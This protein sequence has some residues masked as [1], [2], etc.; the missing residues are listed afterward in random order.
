MFN[1]GDIVKH[2]KI[3]PRVCRELIGIIVEIDKATPNFPY[4]VMWFN[5][6]IS[7][8]IRGYTIHQLIKVS[9]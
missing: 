2:Y 6:D 3:E 9:K 4:A 5:D 8:L 1:V 7:T